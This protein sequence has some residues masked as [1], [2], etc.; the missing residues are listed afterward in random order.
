MWWSFLLR[1][2]PTRRPDRGCTVVEAEAEDVLLA[3]PDAVHAEPA[4]SAAAE[5]RATALLA[6]HAHI[7]GPPIGG[8]IAAVA[9]LQRFTEPTD[10]RRFQAWLLQGLYH[11]LAVAEAS[12]GQRGEAVVRAHEVCAHS[13]LRLAATSPDLATARR[14]RTAMGQ[15]GGSCVATTPLRH[16]RPVNGLGVPIMARP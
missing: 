9:L 2:R 16:A 4:V 8:A 12:R 11:R 15:L 7:D 14:A 5:F 3:A 1:P 6:A 10:P 13:V